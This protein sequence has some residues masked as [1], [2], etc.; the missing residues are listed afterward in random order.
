[1]LI[2]LKGDQSILQI[3][4]LLVRQETTSTALQLYPLVI[5]LPISKHTKRRHNYI[6]DV[7]WH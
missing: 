6:F 7:L 2:P 4:M 5:V 3:G 1:M